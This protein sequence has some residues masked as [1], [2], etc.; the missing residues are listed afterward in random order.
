MN[1]VK[2]DI[3]QVLNRVLE[4]WAMMMVEPAEEEG[5]Q[6]LFQDDEP[7]YVATLA[8][9]GVVSGSYSAVCQREFADNLTANLVGD[10]VGEDEFKDALK[11]LINVVSGNLLTAKWG[12]DTVFELSSP[13]VDELSKE[14]ALKVLCHHPFFLK[15]DDAPIAFTFN[16]G[17]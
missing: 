14:E 15:G 2:E 17:P 9:K 6:E 16:V 13:K 11:E 5:P 1:K 12:E 10:E 7:C 3:A 4:D 8:F